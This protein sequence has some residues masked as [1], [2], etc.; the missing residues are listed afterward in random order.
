VDRV[1]VLADDDEAAV[2]RAARFGVTMMI[3]I[4]IGGEEFWNYICS[5][6]NRWRVLEL[7][8]LCVTLSTGTTWW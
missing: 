4:R 2:A 8:V 5:G 6:G 7:H 3:N 1:G